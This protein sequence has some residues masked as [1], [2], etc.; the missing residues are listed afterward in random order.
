MTINDQIKAIEE[1]IQKTPY[2]K[3]SQHHIGKLKAKLARLKDELEKRAHSG[4][5][6]S[7][8]GVKKSGNATVALVGFPSVGKSTLLNKITTAVSETGS[9]D[10]TTLDTIPG[11][12]V[13]KGARIQ[14]L[15][16]PGLIGGAS[17]GKGRGREVLSAVRCADLILFL[18]DV[19][20]TNMSVLQNELYS[21]GLRLNMQPPNISIKR[22]NRGGITVNYT[23]GHKENLPEE[24]VKAILREWGYVNADAVIHESIDAEMLIDHLRGNCVYLPAI[25]AVNKIDTVTH[26]FIEELKTRLR[27]FN[28]IF[29]S[30]EKGTNLEILKDAIYDTLGFIRIYLKPPGGV[31]DMEKPLV[32]RKGSTIDDVCRTLHRDFQKNFRYANVWGT[33]V[34]FQGQRVG[35][36]H[37]LNDGDILTITLRR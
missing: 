34:K 20:D 13:H 24:T 12:M 2:N 31:A 33:S 4:G 16:L 7:A 11:M 35:P 15:D 27:G 36:T 22:K 26:V 18:I 29:I 10:F 30:A 32:I 21:A 17:A 1:E 9:Y 5:G 8:L 25:T 6:Q 14:I 28:P 3:K 23:G 37:R 19:F